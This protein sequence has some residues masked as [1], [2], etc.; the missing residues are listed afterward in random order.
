[1]LLSYTSSR[2][3][4]A[5]SSLIYTTDILLS[6]LPS[7]GWS[8]C[9]PPSRNQARHQSNRHPI[10]PR[11]ACRSETSWLILGKHNFDFNL[12][13]VLPPVTPARDPEDTTD[14]PD[15]CELSAAALTFLSQT[16][17][18]FSADGRCLSRHRQ[19]RHDA[20]HGGGSD[21]G[22]DNGDF[23][24]KFGT[25]ASVVT[26]NNASS[27]TLDE[28]ARVFRVCPDGQPPWTEEDVKVNGCMHRHP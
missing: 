18:L 14:F 5:L 23:D 20:P 27:T 13:L 21:P 15:R 6:S 11:N 28:V 25:T 2:S 10:H 8:D 24:Y 7:H 4:V 16:F 26:A 12:N 1:M 22:H 3:Q 17:L 9:R 19:V